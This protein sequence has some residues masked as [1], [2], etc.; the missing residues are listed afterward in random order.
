MVRPLCIIPARGGSKRFPRKN[1]AL[2][3]GKPLLLYSVEVALASHLFEEVL[4]ST[5]D[6]EIA[7]IAREAGARVDPRSSGLASDSARLSH[8]CVDIIERFSQ[9][10]EEYEVFCLLQPTCPLRS[11]SDLGT[12]YQLLADRAASY[13]VSVTEYEEPPFWCLSEDPE[14]FLQMMWG[15]DFLTSRQ[16]LPTV[17]KHNGSIVWARSEVFQQEKELLGGSRAVSYHMPRERSIDIDHPLDLKF[18]EL[19]LTEAQRRESFQDR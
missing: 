14:G 12:S 5:E 9:R 8:V 13:V 17:L 19:L 16:Q 4:V 11:S 1:V 2:L 7:G 15:P 3:D 10:G 6:S 18:A